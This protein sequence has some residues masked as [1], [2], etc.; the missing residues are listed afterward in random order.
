MP[1]RA[2]SLSRSTRSCATCCWSRVANTC[3]S[4]QS[5]SIA[6]CCRRGIERLRCI[7][8]RVADGPRK[9][10]GGRGNRRDRTAVRIRGHAPAGRRRRSAPAELAGYGLKI[11]RRAS[12]C[13]I[14]SARPRRRRIRPRTHVDVAIGQVACGRVPG[15]AQRGARGSAR[16]GL[17]RQP[18]GSKVEPSAYDIELVLEDTGEKVYGT[19]AD[20]VIKDMALVADIENARELY[21]G[22]T[23]WTE[24]TVHTCSKEGYVERKGEEELSTPLGFFPVKVIDVV[25]GWDVGGPCDL[26]CNFHRRSKATSMCR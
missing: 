23:L 1:S 13:S 26:S 3:S 19:V 2:A 18:A 24:E 5:S 17:L 25:A 15:D 21:V 6:R 14:S 20:G 22:K 10:G 8:Q 11:H 7:Q 4:P 16:L 9:Q 12:R